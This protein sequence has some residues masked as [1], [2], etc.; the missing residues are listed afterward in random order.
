VEAKSM[1]ELL[2]FK[3]QQK[4]PRNVPPRAEGAEILFFTGVRYMRAEDYAPV[5]KPRRRPEIKRPPLHDQ[6]TC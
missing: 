2:A 6:I 3:T 1:G 4:V 5:A